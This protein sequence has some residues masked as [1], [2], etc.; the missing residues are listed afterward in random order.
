MKD[1]NDNLVGVLLKVIK[2]LEK[3]QLDWA[4]VMKGLLNNYVNLAYSGTKKEGAELI[5]ESMLGGMGSL[6]DLVLYKDGKPL[7]EENEQLDAL[8]DELYD[9]CKKV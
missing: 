8:L 9:E 2:L 3:H 4:E 1:T 5:M 6:S 7:I